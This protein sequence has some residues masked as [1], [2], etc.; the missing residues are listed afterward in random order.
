MLLVLI[1]NINYRGVIMSSVSLNQ[2]EKLLVGVLGFENVASPYV[3]NL[4]LKE[5][6]CAQFLET[7]CIHE[8]KRVEACSP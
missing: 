5:E 7:I 6:I 3:T 1:R 8:H 4:L 2:S